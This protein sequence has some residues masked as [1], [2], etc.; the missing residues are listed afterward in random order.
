MLLN[1]QEITIAVSNQRINTL[2]DKY[3]EKINE[4]SA[5]RDENTKL[6]EE[7]AYLKEMLGEYKNEY[8]ALNDIALSAITQNE[9]FKK[10]E[11]LQYGK[12][13]RYTCDRIGCSE[14]FRI[15]HADETFTT[16]K[17]LFCNM[18]EYGLWHYS[19][20]YR[21]IHPPMGDDQWLDFVY[22]MMAKEEWYKD[23]DERIHKQ[24]KKVMMPAR[25]CMKEPDEMD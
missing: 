13:I 25:P 4:Y 20:K 23:K 15:R 11:D 12:H 14:E 9:G 24:I 1:A 19:H 17:P 2:H 22:R 16:E 3:Q 5:L 8:S 10:R 6:H 18:C 21:N 7:I